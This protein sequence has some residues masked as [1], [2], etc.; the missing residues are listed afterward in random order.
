MATCPA[1]DDK[2]QSLHISANGQG[3]G[4]KCHAGCSNESILA[5]MHLKWGDL[6]YE[7]QPR[8]PEQ[9][10]ATYNYTD[11]RG[12]TLYQSVRYQPKTFKQRQP[13]GNG[14]WIWN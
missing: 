12:Q 14:G 1:H 2:K 7:D 11:E 13:D 3:L 5:C 10:V 4:L 6:F 8:Q 9:I